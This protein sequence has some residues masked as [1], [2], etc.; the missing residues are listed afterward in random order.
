[1]KKIKREIPQVKY[2]EM[3][4]ARMIKGG[5]THRWFEIKLAKELGIPV[6]NCELD[7]TPMPLA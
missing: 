7:I 2:L 5:R 4:L 1:M 6:K 3:K